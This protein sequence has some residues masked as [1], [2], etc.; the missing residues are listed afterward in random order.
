MVFIWLTL[1]HTEIFILNRVFW[2]GCAK[3]LLT[4]Q[5]RHIWFWN[6]IIETQLR[7]AT[8]ATKAQFN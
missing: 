6:Q 5:F 4:V 2:E 3:L 8:P 7:V 1:V